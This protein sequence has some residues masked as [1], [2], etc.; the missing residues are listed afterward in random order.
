ML[1]T[2]YGVLLSHDAGMTWRWLCED[3]LGVLSNSTTDPVLAMTTGSIVG[4]PGLT[5]G[6]FVS[7]DGGCNWAMAAAPLS[8]VLTK[9]LVVRPGAPDAVLAL[10]STYAPHA[11]ADGGPGYSQQVYASVDDGASWSAFGTPIDPSALA[12]S[13]ELAASDTSRVYI[14]TIRGANAARTASLFVSTD[15]GASWTERPVPIDPNSEAE[16]YVGAVDPMNADRVYVRTLGQ[17]SRLLVTSDAGQTY[18]SALS[19]SGQMLGFALSP[20]GSKVYAGSIEDGL[21]AATRDSLAFQHVSAVHVQCLAAH[22][23]DLWACSDEPSG[24]VAGVSSDD[25]ATFTARAHLQAQP[26]IACAADAS[27]AQCS[28]APLQ[29][30]CAQL[31]GCD[32]DGGRAAAATNDGGAREI[33]SPGKARGCSAAGHAE[34]A[35]ALAAI[36]GFAAIAA[37]GRRRR[38]SRSER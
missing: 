28:G 23:A 32:S 19:L 21:F 14:S 3:V 30:L 11:G 33:P 10:T 8:D 6:L 5:A 35:V 38:R 16:I 26:P 31:P 18:Q 13:I 15:A 9:D 17:P 34:G 29:A 25:G 20:D 12:T 1:R 4:G 7:P 2:T 37:W 27:A 22:G 36:G 24:F